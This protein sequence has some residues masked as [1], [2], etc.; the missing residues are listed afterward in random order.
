MELLYSDPY[1]D[2]E[3]WDPDRYA[4][5]VKAVV[6]GLDPKAGVL[7]DRCRSWGRLP[8]RDSRTSCRFKLE[9]LNRSSCGGC[10][11]LQGKSYSGESGSLDCV[12]EE[13]SRP[14][15]ADRNLQE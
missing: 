7:E 2:S 5:E 12:G 4:A 11:F 15:Q 1:Y 13:V 14:H 8:Q 10:T 9:K 6:A 3:D